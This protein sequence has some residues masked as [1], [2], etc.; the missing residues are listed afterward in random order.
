MAAIDGCLGELRPN[1]NADTRAA[2]G[3]TVS[4]RSR[5]QAAHVV[6]RRRIEIRSGERPISL[7]APRRFSCRAGR[8]IGQHDRSSSQPRSRQSAIP[9]ARGDRACRRSDGRSR[10]QRSGSRGFRDRSARSGGWRQSSARIAEIVSRHRRDRLPDQPAGAERRGRSGARRRRRQGFRRGRDPRCARWRSVPA[11]AAK[12]IKGLIV[13]IP[14]SRSARA[15]ASSARTG[16]L[17]WT[18]SSLRPERSPKPLS[19]RFRLRQAPQS[20]RTGHRGDEPDGRR[21]GRDDSA[22]FGAGRA[23]RQLRAPS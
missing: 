1:L 3:S 21:Y 18:G 14:T 13:A 20:R 7:S 4:R 9:L 6:A 11:T 8:N 10:R 16:E 12:D 19:P 15:C 23:E 5:R 2:D 17:R 22:E